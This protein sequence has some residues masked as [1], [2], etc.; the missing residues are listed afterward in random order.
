MI[1]LWHGHLS[2]LTSK[3]SKQTKERT[4]T[5]RPE[6]KPIDAL[7]IARLCE[8][9]ATLR[10]HLD[11]SRQTIVAM[12]YHR[13]EED[14]RRRGEVDKEIVRLGRDIKKLKE[15]LQHERREREA[16]QRT[17]A[18]LGGGLDE[19]EWPVCANDDCV[20]EVR[21]K[22][23]NALYCSEQCKWAV[24]KRRARAKLAPCQNEKCSEKVEGKRKG[25]RYCSAKCK[26]SAGVRRHRANNGGGES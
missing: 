16:A 7:T 1:Q 9:I 13:R 10:G 19:F 3:Q 20:N 18:I 15:K 4:M 8:E 22:R 17:I 12:D 21:S 14:K 26:S 11:A 6:E 5:D 25:A 2:E 23:S 24:Q